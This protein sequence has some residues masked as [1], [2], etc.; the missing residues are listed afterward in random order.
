[1]DVG[2]GDVWFLATFC[3]IKIW[4]PQFSWHVLGFYHTLICNILFFSVVHLS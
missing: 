4:L 1:M 2:R 3:K